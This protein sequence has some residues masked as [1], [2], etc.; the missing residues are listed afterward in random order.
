MLGFSMAQE[1]E[2][3]N[4]EAKFDAA[5]KVIWSLP[6]EGPF[7]PSDD[8]LLRFYAYHMQATQGPCN[9]PRPS[10][11]WDS[12]G[13]VKWDAWSSL[14][15]MTKV[16][17]MNNYIQDIQLI[18][19]TIPISDEVSDLVQKLDNFFMEVDTFDDEENDVNSRSFSRPFEQHG[20]EQ[21]NQKH[22]PMMEGYGDL[23]DD[24]QNVQE[25]D[26][27]GS[28]HGSSSEE[29]SKD[30]SE[31]VRKEECSDWKSEE[32]EMGDEED[33]T[34]DK[35]EDWKV[36]TPDQ[37]L[38]MVDDTR[39]RADTRGSSSSVEA[40]VS[41][42]TNG[43]HSSLNTE[44]EED[45]LAYSM[46]RSRQGNTY[47]HFNGHVCEHL[48][49]I[50][51]KNQRSTDSDNEEFC[52]SMEHLAVEEGRSSSKIL[53]PGSRA[54]SVR[55]M[56]LWFDS[57]SG[58]NRGESQVIVADSFF[59]DGMNVRQLH[60][61]LSSRGRASQA[62]RATCSSGLCAGVDAPCSVSQSSRAAGANV[63]E[64][65][66]AALMRLQWDMTNVVHRLHALEARTSSRSRSSLRQ[67]NS[68]P[69]EKKLPRPSWWPFD[70]CPLTVVLYALWPLITHWGVHVYL[71]HKR[72]KI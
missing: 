44:M 29:S 66:A 18:L 8:M 42:L 56:D 37:S 62:S 41:S 3:N 64:Q 12:R 15:N 13:K 33:N 54:D 63:N 4:L 69:L 52:D 16:E 11:F 39:W 71:K 40:S 25:H 10:S 68:L 27:E 65:I 46:E 48:D 36:W 9:I 21:E 58:R 60:S 67:E 38:L 45:E 47:T 19:E 23:W 57:S 2:E 51:H 43:T 6:E 28:V 70:F 30:A 59:K 34:E 24:I 26:K 22:K 17:A 31:L 1:E 53:P 20:D 32:E 50:L 72:R 35:D 14:G 5:V 49:P 7:Q 55:Q 61:S